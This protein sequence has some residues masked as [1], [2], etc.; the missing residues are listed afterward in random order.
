MAD[1]RGDEWV[2]GGCVVPW[3][4]GGRVRVR[5]SGGEIA[6]VVV[7]MVQGYVWVSVSPPFTWEAIMTVGMIDEVVGVL[8]VAREE[9]ERMGEAGDTS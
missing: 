6:I 3:E 7:R 9:A 1:D 5:A 2:G 8:Q 4:Q